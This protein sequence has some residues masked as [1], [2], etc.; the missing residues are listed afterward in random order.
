MT[1]SCEHSTKVLQF[2]ITSWNT[3][4]NARGVGTE[5]ARDAFGHLCDNYWHPVYAYIRRKGFDCDQAS[6]YTQAFFAALLEKNSLGDV[7]QAKG[8]LRSFLLVAVNHFLLNQIARERTLKRGGAYKILRLE[9]DTAERL[10]RRE[11]TNELTPETIF[12]YHWALNLLGRTLSHLRSIHS[13][14]EFDILKPFL[15]GEADRGQIAIVG[16]RQGMSGGALKVAVH[17]LRRRFREILRAEIAS[18]VSDPSQVDEEIR[19]LLQVFSR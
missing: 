14:V 11:L 12:E 19:H 17:R 18:T 4:A 9:Q 15:L 6:D 10:Y 16:E 5:S 2:P 8:R 13:G 3:I 1:A 7:N